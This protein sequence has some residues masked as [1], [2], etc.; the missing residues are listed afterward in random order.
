MVSTA[1]PS[2]CLTSLSAMA[3]FKRRHFLQLTGSTLATLGINQLDVFRQGDRYAKVLAQ[4]TPRKLALLVG[5]NNY[6]EKSNFAPLNGCLT[7]VELQRQLLIYR[8]GFKPQ[9]ILVLTDAQ[10][11][12]K[13]ILD[14]FENHL[15]KQAKSDDIVVFHYSGHGS[16]V[17]DPDYRPGDK[18]EYVTNSTLVPFDS[19]IPA[20]FPGKVGI[21]NDILGRGLFLLM[22]SL[23]TENVTVVLDSCH[24]GG[25]TRNQPPESLRVTSLRRQDKKGR[26]QLRSHGIEEFTD[27]LKPSPEELEFHENRRTNLGLSKE[28]FVKRRR[29]GVAKGIVITSAKRDQLAADAPFNDFYAGAFTYTMTQYLWQQ[30]GS[31]TYQASFPAIARA[32]R[33]NS[34]S[35][36]E[37]QIEVKPGSNNDRKKVYL[38]E[39]Q[40]LPAEAV[41][42]DVQGGT[43]KIWLGGIP[44]QTLVAFDK[45]AVLNA[46]DARGQ[47]RGQVQIQSRD[48]LIGIGKLL[49]A[50]A[51]PGEL[52]QEQTRGIPSNLSLRVGIDTS[53]K[54]GESA[55]RA[56]QS[57]NRVEAVAPGQGEANYV[58]G[59]ITPNYLKDLQ[60]TAARGTELPPL[61]SIG[62]FYPGLDMVPGSF[63]RPNEEV[64]DAIVRLQPKLKSLLAARLVKLTL[65]ANSSRL[66][67]A[68]SMQVRGS[69]ATEAQTFD[70]R[71]CGRCRPDN[72]V[73]TTNPR[74]LPLGTDVF[75]TVTNQESQD[76]YVNV[77]VIDSVGDMAVIFPN[78]WVASA[79]AMRVPAGTQVQI[80]NPDDPFTFKTQ[81]PLGRTEVL[82]I[83]SVTPLNKSLQALQKLASRGAQTRGPVAL[84]EPTDMI[85]SLLE[86]LD[87]TRS[88]PGSAVRTIDVAQIAAMS[89]SFDVLDPSSV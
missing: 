53:L 35:E 29:T 13:G 9:D 87:G 20:E 86:D 46:I 60:K 83:A 38:T 54:E 15:I 70:V 28:E 56:L 79:D 69:G 80:P 32:T 14:A 76:L 85:G 1:L 82:V 2:L 58:L 42:T 71:G 34:S 19:G 24:S 75:F 23:Q 22:S 44:P 81:K 49:N 45:N 33:Q 67:V 84:N 64:A 88:A 72:S 3:H 25:A 31:T 43:A 66:N 68:A 50:S 39:Q 41:I 61:G 55:R 57:V 4:G 77:F 18:V 11:T 7:D 36:Q 89:I 26:M 74:A 63:G 21:V 30:T 62:L 27:R 12:R 65:N 73:G 59:R 10:A 52:L 51:T 47:S 6:P 8:F 17:A 37:P 48:G 40:A 5:I 16:Q 78:N